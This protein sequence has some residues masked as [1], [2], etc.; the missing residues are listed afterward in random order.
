MCREVMVAD[1]TKAACAVCTKW[2]LLALPEAEG[3][4][5]NQHT[6]VKAVVPQ[7]NGTVVEFYD[8]CCV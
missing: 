6:N 8:G 7:S 2:K 1:P 5:K 4:G 3:R